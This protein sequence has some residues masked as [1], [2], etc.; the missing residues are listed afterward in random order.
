MG[1]YEKLMAMANMNLNFNQKLYRILKDKQY[2]Q[3]PFQILDIGDRM[4][5]ICHGYYDCA[6][7]RYLLNHKLREAYE[8][9][10]GNGLIM[11]DYEQMPT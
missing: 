1:T 2:N 6:I 5:S 4:T 10:N 9:I 11:F 7:V 3:Y 8:V